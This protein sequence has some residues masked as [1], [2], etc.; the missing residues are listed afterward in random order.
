MIL[1]GALM[2]DNP[3]TLAIAAGTQASANTLD[4][5]NPDLGLVRSWASCPGLH[6]LHLGRRR[7]SVL[8]SSGFGR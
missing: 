8:R 1:D 4:L 5:V 6:D 3:S 7:H 2:F